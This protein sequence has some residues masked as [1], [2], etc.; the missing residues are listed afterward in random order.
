MHLTPTHACTI[1]I[2]SDSD[3]FTSPMLFGGDCIIAPFAVITKQPLFTQDLS[4]TAFRDEIEF[5]YRLYPNIAYPRYWIDSSKYDFSSLLK[6]EVIN[7]SKFTRTTTAK[8]NLD[9][10]FQDGGNVFRVDDSYMYTS[11]NGIMEFIC[12]V[13]YNIWFREKSQVPFYS[14]QSSD[15]NVILRSDHLK[16]TEEFKL[17]ESYKH[18]LLKEIAYKTPTYNQSDLLPQEM[19]NALVYS[20]PSFQNLQTVDNWQY[21]LPANF[22][23]FDTTDFGN[24]TGI[25]KL[26]QDRIIFLFDKSSPFISYGQD[27]LQMDGTGR[28][29]IIGDGGLFAQQPRELIPTDVNYAAS[30]SPYAFSATQFGYLYP[31]Q[32][33]GRI[34]NYTNNLDDVSRQGAS[35]WCET[36]MPI[37]LYETFPNYKQKENPLSRVG[38]L[39]VVDSKLETYYITKRDFSPKFKEI[40]YNAEEDQFYFKNAKIELRD[41]N[42]FKDNSWTLSYSPS[43][44]GFVSFHDWHPDWTIQTETKFFTVE[45]TLILKH[46]DRCDSFCE[47]NGV[48]YPYSLEWCVNSALQT[49]ILGSVEVIHEAFTYKNSCRDKILN[50]EFFD[51]LEVYNNE[52][53]SGKITLIYGT[54]FLIQNQE[55]PIQKANFIEALYSHVENRFRVNQFSDITLD[56]NEF[57]IHLN[58]EDGYTREYNPKALD[59]QKNPE[60]QKLLRSNANKIRFTKNKSK[61]NKL[62]TKFNTS[63]ITLSPR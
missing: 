27:E 32:S 28:K 49:H 57:H 47:F 14:K 46:N 38:Y 60:D 56:E 18:L 25:H 13:D 53:N 17:N 50:S 4:D 55:Y 26:D 52:Q 8:Y 9:C 35:F 58:H 59:Y 44:K 36:Y 63:K 31:S 45:D 15:V 29:I 48:E 12:E 22:Y 43:S 21:F 37:Q 40:T 39:T 24:L 33:Q 6:K 3:K 42:Y 62:I 51:Q 41:S 20:L 19:K 11:V 30:Q 1:N 54:D 34:F 7:Y 5:D 23:N 2:S 16:Q 10:K 61:N